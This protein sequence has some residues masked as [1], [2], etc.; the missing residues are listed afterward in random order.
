MFSKPHNILKARG[1]ELKKNANSF[2]KKVI[3]RS[4]RLSWSAE[5]SNVEQTL[6]KFG[7]T[8]LNMQAVPLAGSIFEAP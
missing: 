3:P 8:R 6:V 7:Q 2:M 4:A 5:K 1:S